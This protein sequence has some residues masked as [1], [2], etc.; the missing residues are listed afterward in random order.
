MFK[1]LFIFLILIL[2]LCGIFF[3]A[4][5]IWII[6][7][8]PYPEKVNHLQTTQSTK[9]YDRT[10][11]VLLYEVYGDQNR[12]MLSAEEIPDFV[13]KATVAVEDQNFYKHSALDWTAFLRAV[14]VNLKK[15]DFSQGGSTIT[16]QFVKNAFLTPEK[17]IE[18][19]IK[20]WILA[21][22]LE[23]NYTKDEILVF[24]LNQIPY[25]SNAYGIESAS[26][27]FFGKKAKD[28]T[29]A[30]SALAVSVVQS[31]T[32]YSPW[33]SHK[34]ELLNRKNYVLDQMLSLGYIDKEQ[35]KSAKAEQLKF[36]S[37][38]I[39]SIKAPH[40][41]I[42]VKNYLIEKYGEDVVERG[43]LKVITTLDWEKQMVAEKV[44][45]EGAERN[46]D[47][48]KGNNAAMVVEDPK[49][50]QILSLVG[51]ADYFNQEI[52]GNFNVAVQGLRQPGSTFKPFAHVTAF[53]KGYTPDSIVFDVPTEFSV[54]PSCPAVV[55]FSVK[56]SSC[57]HP[58]NFDNDFKGP[59]SLK[60][61]L[62]Q[63]INVPSVKVLYL[64]GLEETIK[65]AK[66]MGITTLDDISRF[67]LS[68]VLGGGEIKLIDLVGAY[69][70]FSQ[71]GVK[72]DQSFILSVKNYKGETLEEVSDSPEQVIDSQYAKMINNILS[73][74]E[75][76]SGLFHSSLS[77][78][79]FDG[80][81]VALK[82]GTTNDYR[83]AWVVGY[84]PNLV[85][86]VWAGNS[87][88]KPMQKQ[89][90]SILAAIPIWSNY[91]N[92]VIHNYPSESFEKAEYQNSPKPMLNGKYV[93]EID[94]NG[95]L[96]PNV[97]NILFYLN[98]KD[99]FSDN[100]PGYDS[101]DSQF[102]NWETSVINWAKVNIPNFV[103]SYNK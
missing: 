98:R 52:D 49:T 28:L 68:L 44:V 27:L 15:G 57:F 95:V 64:A 46:S 48:Y 70:V 81:D 5:F 69:S 26:Q 87:N 2:L 80:Y 51:S 4:Y 74:V 96:S 93:N 79:V 20:E 29:L 22:W 82:T 77:Y 31:P 62:A 73:D 25:G 36:I 94:R 55:D 65:T 72:H 56:N 66:K 101:Q 102:N 78:T 54:D 90:G 92:Q 43:G 34:Q 23:R 53:L 45:K 84:T 71:D 91:L 58:Q 18:R 14:L 61:A 85:V 12:T 1:K 47:L 8:L 39:G 9:I 100:Y 10:G 41:S 97:H 50:G 76:R 19:K 67:G 75:L 83:D 30:E 40:F 3:S 99:I 88:N 32:Y 63:S 21:Y 33:G 16:Q 37:Q 7:N 6:K 59:V 24:Y 86:G 35:L 89:G 60:Q 17:T 13:K 11:D 38:T 103:G 42:M